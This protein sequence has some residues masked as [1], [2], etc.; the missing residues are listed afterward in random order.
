MSVNPRYPTYC[1]GGLVHRSMYE[2]SNACAYRPVCAIDRD[3]RAAWVWKSAEQKRSWFGEPAK[4]D[5]DR[6]RLSWPTLPPDAPRDAPVTC[7]QCLYYD[8]RNSD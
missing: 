3:P 8:G 4:A 2:E 5:S 6:G 1:I 7:L